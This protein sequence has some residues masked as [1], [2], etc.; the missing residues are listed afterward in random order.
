MVEHFEC[1]RIRWDV[2]KKYGENL[3]TCESTVCEKLP[4]LLKNPSSRAYTPFPEGKGV[5]LFVL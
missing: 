5:I 2:Q 4:L 3:M 1:K